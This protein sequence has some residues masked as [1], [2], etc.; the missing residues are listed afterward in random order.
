MLG[1][2]QEDIDTTDSE[3]SEPE[4]KE[5]ELDDEASSELRIR[6]I[7]ALQQRLL[8]QETSGRLLGREAEFERLNSWTSE[9]LR[10]GEGGSFYICGSPGTGKTATM[11]SLLSE[12]PSEVTVIELNGMSITTPASIYGLLYGAVFGEEAGSMK[13]VAAKNALERWLAAADTLT[14]VVIDEMDGLLTGSRQQ[15][16]YHLFGW[17]Q[18][19]DCRLVLFGIANSIDL[20]DRFLPRLKQRNLEPEL[21]IFRPYTKTQLVAIMKHR[22]GGDRKNSSD[23]SAYF[24]DIAVTLCAQKVAKMYGDVRKC[25]ELCRNALNVLLTEEREGGGDG[26]RKIGFLEMK[27]VLSASFQSPLID[28]IRDLP[29]QQKTI[30]VMALLLVDHHKQKRQWVPYSKLEQFYQFMAKKHLL[31]KTASREFRVIV[32]S[33]ITDNIVQP[34]QRL[35]GG[36]GLGNETKLQIMVS[37]DDIQFAFRDDS[38]LRKF[39]DMKLVIPPRFLS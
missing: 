34:L 7:Q 24:E 8:T 27:G 13:P 11:R 1:L 14:V 17:T 29:N 16:L 4:Q 10:L 2:K 30:L 15:V 37:F 26:A 23:Y 38:V 39:F 25:L 32:D 20:T 28:I 18:Q 36:K 19:R 5:L 6:N 35:R 22:L 9:R 31:P 33:L 3:Q 12:L 21:L